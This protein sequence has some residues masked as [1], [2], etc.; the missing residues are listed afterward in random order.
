MIEDLGFE[1]QVD[2]VPTTQGS[3]AAS[4]PVADLHS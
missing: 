1:I 3:T 2:A 4:E